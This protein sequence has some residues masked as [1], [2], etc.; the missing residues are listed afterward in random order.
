MNE[1]VCSERVDRERGQRWE[2]PRQR[3]SSLVCVTPGLSLPELKEL[4]LT[5]RT[6]TQHGI[7]LVL[8]LTWKGRAAWTQGGR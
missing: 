2:R 6:Q 8:D 7:V 1:S 5:A 3:F 4:A